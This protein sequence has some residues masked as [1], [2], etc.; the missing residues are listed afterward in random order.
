MKKIIIVATDENAKTIATLLMDCV[1]D[2]SIRSIEEEART[3]TL[4]TSVKQ[5]ERKST[6]RSTS[7]KTSDEELFSFIKNMER[8]VTIQ[9]LYS[10]MTSVGFAQ[11]TTHGPLN[12][13]L[14]DKVI[15]RG[16]DGMISLI[17][18]PFE[19]SA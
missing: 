17:E 6:K 7:G 5:Q 3:N 13:L 11:S 15:E 2:I 16:R 10:H 12:R 1:A 8:P 4:T 14:A 18:K 9:E 19:L